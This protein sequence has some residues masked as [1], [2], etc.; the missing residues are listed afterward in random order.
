MKA[1]VQTGVSTAEVRDIE[2]PE[3]GPDD[4]IINVRRAGLCGSDVHAYQ[5]VDGFEFIPF[6]RVM[7]HE[8]AGEIVDKGDNVDQ[9]SEGDKVVEE[10]IHNCGQCFQCKNGQT[11]ACKDT[12]ITGMH[13][14]GA[15]TK[16]TSVN[17]NHV[18]KVPDSVPFQE[19]AITEPTSVAARAVLEQSMA[20]S[21]DK[22]LVEGPGPIGALIA[23]I[24][25][26][27]GLDVLVSGVDRDTKHRLPLIENWGLETINI[28]EENLSDRT[29]SFTNGIGFDVVFDA[30]GHKSGVETAS[31]NVRKGGQ[32]VVAGLPAAPAEIFFTPLVRGEIDLNTSYGSTWRNFEQALRLMSNGTISVGDITEGPFGIQEIEDTIHRFEKGEMTKPIFQFDDI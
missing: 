20:N 28:S 17:Q 16:F 22:V 2:K 11:N 8:Y 6:P 3:P 26:S 5:Y 1:F 4:V 32:I 18:H 10:P 19:A 31:E 25:D 15:Y 29:E 21:G 9:F 27:I 24:A 30:T 7:G 12:T 14:D 13:T 23:G